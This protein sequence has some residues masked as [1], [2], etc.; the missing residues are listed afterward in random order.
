[1][2]GQSVDGFEVGGNPTYST[3][4]STLSGNTSGAN[5]DTVKTASAKALQ[6]IESNKAGDIKKVTI[7]PRIQG[8][9]TPAVRL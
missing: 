6:N 5:A 4:P 7:Q 8:K 9:F 3:V 2:A 1:M